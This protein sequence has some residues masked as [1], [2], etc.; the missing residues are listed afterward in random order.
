MIVIVMQ[1]PKCKSTKTVKNGWR[2]DKQNYLCR[3]CNRQ[4]IDTY[5]SRSYSDEIKDHCLTLY[6]NGMGAEAFASQSSISQRYITNKKQD[7]QRKIKSY[8]L[9]V[10]SVATKLYLQGTYPSEVAVSQYLDKPGYFRY[11]EVRNT[12]KHL[13]DNLI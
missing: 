12:L 2:G 3:N 5:D 4:F 8:C 7:S 9:E 1:C 11:K 6:C 13:Q 10:E